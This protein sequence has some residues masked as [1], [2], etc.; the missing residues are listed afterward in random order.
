[1]KYIVI[2]ILVILILN[3]CQYKGLC[4]ENEVNRKASPNKVMDAVIVTKDCGATA[5]TAYYVYITR[6]GAKDF[7]NPLL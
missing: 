3:G 6:I 2:N 4:D 1:M 5:S 7:N